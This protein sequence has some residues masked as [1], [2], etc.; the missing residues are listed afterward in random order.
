MPDISKIR[1]VFRVA[2]MTIV[3]LMLFWEGLDFPKKEAHSMFFF[4][5][6][7]K[8]EVVKWRSKGE[9]KLRIWPEPWAIQL[10]PPDSVPK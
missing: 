3:A 9:N 2:T 5:P 8:T 7:W 1:Y 6:N 10:L 4:G